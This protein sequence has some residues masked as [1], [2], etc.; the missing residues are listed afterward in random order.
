MGLLQLLLD[1]FDNQRSIPLEPVSPMVL[2]RAVPSHASASVVSAACAVG[3]VTIAVRATMRVQVRSIGEN[4]A[5]F[6]TS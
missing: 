4:P 6:P 5:V 1:G 2:M 3:P